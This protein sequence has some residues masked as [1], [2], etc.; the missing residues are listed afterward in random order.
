MA[1]VEAA[2]FN[3]IGADRVLEQALACDFSIR[4]A[5]R[6]RL[7]KSIIRAQQGRIDEAISEI[8]QIMPV[9]NYTVPSKKEGE[10]KTAT[11]STN[12]G[13]DNIKEAES[14]T[15]AGGNLYSDSLRLTDDDRVGAFVCYSSL[16]G[17]ARRMKEAN[18]VLAHAK[19]Q[20]AGSAQ[21]VQVLVAASQLYVEK[22]D[23]DSAI[24][25]LDKISE[26]SPTFARAQLIKADI[27]LNHNHDKEGFTKCYQ[28]LADKE[29]TAKNF[30][31]LGEAYLRIL[32]PEAAIDAL[33]RAYKLDPK[34]GRL[35]GRIG[36][37][38]VAT[39]EYHRAVEFYE[40]AIREL[41]KAVTQQQLDKKS[42]PADKKRSGGG[43]GS[44]GAANDIVVLS[45]DLSKLYIKLGE[46]YNLSLLFFLL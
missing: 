31:L 6:F 46:I 23:F 7:V 13:L 43:S 41:N 42:G 34:N 35:R 16:L 30:A 18:K 38:L 9:L 10:A 22:G 32:N 45:H 1:S 5:P 37:A 21:E 27:V 26:D 3:T 36:R 25:M 33:E 20:F 14:A 4:S 2:Q 29:P 44:T 11:Y 15:G 24:R 8:E 12:A 39:H 19:V 40:A 28:Q 17:K